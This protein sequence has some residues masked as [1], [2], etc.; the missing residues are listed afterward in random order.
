MALQYP[1]AIGSSMEL[2]PDRRDPNAPTPNQRNGK[3][4]ANYQV[5]GSDPVRNMWVLQVGPQQLRVDDATYQRLVQARI[6][7]SKTARKILEEQAKPK[8]PPI[9]NRAGQP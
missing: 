7:G 9:F 4:G 2:R 3:G 8:D 6:V 1:L 5:L